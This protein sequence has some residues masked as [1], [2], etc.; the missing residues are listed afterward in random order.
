MVN[1]RIIVG[2]NVVRRFEKFNGGEDFTA[3]GSDIYGNFVI[4]IQW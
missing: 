4:Q 3:F 1:G 2:D